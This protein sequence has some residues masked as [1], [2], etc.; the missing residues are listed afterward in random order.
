[1]NFLAPAYL[2]ALAAVAV[3]ILIHIFTRRRVPEVPW[4]SIRFLR[5]ADRRSMARINI[6]RLLLL[7][8][9][10]AGIAL[11]A[12]ALARPVVRG[13]LASLFP[14]GGSRAV[15]IL[16]DRSYSMG[17]ETDGGTAFD[18]ARARIEP[19]L[20]ELSGGDRVAVV[21]FDT[22][23]EVVYDG[24]RDAGAIL[25]ALAGASVSWRGTDLGAAVAFGR[26]AL[27]RSQRETREL[28]VLSDFQ[29]SGLGAAR[30]ARESNE[31]PVR[32]ILLPIQAADPANAAIEEVST[33]RAALHRGETAEIKIVL[34]NAAPDREARFPIEVEASGRRV[35][36]K[37]IA[38]RPG[39]TAVE[40]AVIRADR[41][42]WIEGVVRKRA[43]RL[44]ADDARYFTLRVREK[45]NVLLV[46]DGGGFYLE[47]ALSPAGGEGDVALA[48][49]GSRELVSADLDRAD[50]VVLGP[51]RGLERRDVE[52]LRRFVAAG[53]TALVLVLPEHA[54]AVE[55]LSRAA[56]SIEF[57][58]MPQ[59]YFTIARP[60][61]P[62]GF[63]APFGEEDLSALARLRFRRAAFVR[64]AKPSD[65]LLSFST[66]NPF[67]WKERLGGGAVVFACIDPRP[68]AG[69]L[70][71]SPFFLPLVQQIVL[72]AGAGGAPGDGVLVGEPIIFAGG[73][74]GEIAARMPD[75]SEWRSAPDPGAGAAGIA[76]PP[77]R[78]PG[79]VTI[80]VGAQVEAI[81]AVNPDCR[82]ESDLSYLAAD[83]AADSL[84]LAHRTAVGEGSDLPA[85]VRAAREGKEIAL[86][87]LLAAIAVLA[88]ELAVA[89]R[90]REEAGESRVG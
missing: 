86:P 62:P 49:R 25:A 65:V 32:A 80:T 10:I 66:G 75:G 24:E 18:R 6:R 22:A 82:R 85:A 90:S 33:P 39:G 27:D 13:S 19:L 4:G 53:G 61:R 84:G 34:R 71:L 72:A 1:M 15:C 31:R 26:S 5:P 41:S 51:G 21:L 77:A 76:V 17:V 8:L 55:R 88:A 45:A 14:A 47:Q 74:R 69:E 89:Q 46:S 20:A 23:A 70:V 56:L 35:M 3:P 36:E 30:A 68:E 28:Y 37:E 54:G 78:E 79:F 52:L 63:L 9:R 2:L 57:A 11:V 40:T 44:A 67:V 43:D 59:G 42:G 48:T 38:I 29:R 73:A 64:G 7:A 58:D 50:A 83:E 60:E 12:L 16:L 81:V 87:L